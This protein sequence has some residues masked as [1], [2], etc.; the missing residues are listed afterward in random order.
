MPPP[1]R[2]GGI[3]TQK[4]AA[5]TST[6]K[7]TRLRDRTA[8]AWFSCLVRHP[9]RNRE[10]VYSFNAGANSEEWTNLMGLSAGK[11]FLMILALRLG[12]IPECDKTERHT[13]LQYQY[14]ASVMP[15]SNKNRITGAAWL[16]NTP[17]SRTNEWM[18]ARLTAISHDNQGQPVPERL[19]T[20]FY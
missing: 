6:L 16:T 1:I 17:S 13:E 15:V 18:N 20:G 4:V 9:A 10:R 3:T 2:G 8:T 5:V 7:K 11:F 12:Y 14:R 19:H